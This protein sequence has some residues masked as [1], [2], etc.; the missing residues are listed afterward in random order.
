MSSNKKLI[1]VVALVLAVA[2]YWFLLLAPKRE[3]A[4]ALADQVATKQAA[5]Q[6][7]EATV[8]TY[9]K[10]RGAYRG[11]YATVVRLG[12]AVPGDD[13]VRS[14]MVQMD[15]AAARSGVDFRTIQVGGSASG[16]DSTATGPVAGAATPPPG[17]QTVGTAGFWVMPLQ[18]TFSGDFADLSVFFAKLERFVSVSEQQIDVTGRLLRV[19]SVHLERDGEGQIL[20][21]EVGASS[22]LVPPTE[23]VTGGASTQGPATV[24][25]SATPEA[26][27][28]TP[29]TATTT[30]AI[31]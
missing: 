10:A 3:E 27:G 13:D 1:G 31:R 26:G 28:A 22:Y 30:G 20:R 9:Q 21:A 4:A 12:K 11:N 6:A 8:A 15:S 24:T 29:P 5:V 14:L 19:D 23:G 18:L 17:A 2:G 25:A 16:A 7:A